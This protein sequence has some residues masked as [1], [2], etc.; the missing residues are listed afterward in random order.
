MAIEK[1]FVNLIGYDRFMRDRNNDPQYDRHLIVCTIHYLDDVF[2]S[3]GSTV[4]KI[5]YS[6]S[7]RI[8]ASSWS[9]IKLSH[10]GPIYH[11]RRESEIQFNTI[12][13]RVLNPVSHLTVFL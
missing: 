10:I 2:Q 1:N 4:S 12:M 9:V 7:G 8:I 3:C 13:T 11:A 6:R 5:V